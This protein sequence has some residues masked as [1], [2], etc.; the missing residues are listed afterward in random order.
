MLLFVASPQ[1]LLTSGCS[2]PVTLQG[3]VPHAAAARLVCF[4]AN[5]N[6]PG[7]NRIPQSVTLPDVHCSL[8]FIHNF[9]H[10]LCT[11]IAMQMVQYKVLINN[12][13]SKV[14]NVYIILVS[15]LQLSNL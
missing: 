11:T 8:R 13:I 15:I 3:A 2:S 14:K 5:C 6:T 12:L 7:N 9:N 4:P 1:L 10:K